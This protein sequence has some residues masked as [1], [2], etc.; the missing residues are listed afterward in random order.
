M[1]RA[2]GESGKLGDRYEA[3]WTVDSLLDVLRGEAE[4]LV[5]E[6][7]DP[8]E[9]LGIEFKKAIPV[10]V[11]FHSAKRQTTRQVW[12]V[13]VL[14]RPDKGRSV[15]GDLFEKLDLDPKNHVVFVSGTTARDLEEICAW[16][17]DSKD[18]VA[19]NSRIEACPRALRRDFEDRILQPQFG[20]DLHKG[21]EALRRIRVVGWT[22]REMIRRV[23]QR[24]RDTLYHT[25]GT[26]LDT[27]ACRV[28]LAEI[29]HSTFGQQIT[30]KDIADFLAK[31]RI[32]ERDW[33]REQGPRALVEKRNAAYIGNVE[34]E[35]IAGG[36][37]DREE[38]TKATDALIQ[39]DKKRAVVIGTAGMGKSCTAAQ[40]LVQL[41][42]N[43]I[44]AV[45]IRLDIQTEVLTSRRLGEELGLP[46]SPAVVLAGIA[47]GG[48]C[49]LVID[50]LDAISFASGRNQRLWQVFEEMLEEAQDYPQMR[51]LLACRAF[52]AEHDPRIRRFLA[53][54]DSTIR[55]D[56]G[57]LSNEAV[58]EIIRR[59]A[60]VDPAELGSAHIDLLRTPLHL[61]LYLQGDP[62]SQPRFSGVQDLFGRYW[63]YKR[64]LVSLQLGRESRWHDIIS[65]LVN[66]LSSDQTLSAPRT[67]LDPFDETEIAI[68]ASLNVIVLDGGSVRFFHEAFFDYCFARLFA[69][70]DQTVLEFLTE[71]GKEQ[72]LF[73]R[74]QV[75][76]ILEYER[77]RNPERYVRNLRDLLTSEKIRYHLKQLTIDWLAAISDPR[78]DEWRL[79]EALGISSALGKSAMYIPWNRPAWVLLL[80]R[81]GVWERWLESPN[82]EFVR[83]AVQ[84]LGLPAAMEMCSKEIAQLFRPYVYSEKNW[85]EEFGHLFSFG[86]PHH[87]LEMFELFCEATRRKLVAAPTDGDWYQYEKLAREK[88]EY[89]V[90]WLSVLL[91]LEPEG[92]DD[93][94][95]DEQKGIRS[96]FILEIAGLAPEAFARE[97]LPRIVKRL[98][99]Q[100]RTDVMSFERRMLFRRAALGGT[101]TLAALAHGLEIAM[102]TLSRESP[103]IL[104]SIVMAV[105]G[106]CHDYWSTLLLSA[107]GENGRHYA[108][109]I[110]AYL[111]D[112]PERLGLKMF[113]WERASGLEA[114]RSA[115]PYCSEEL[116]AK[117]ESQIMDYTASSEKSDPK[118]IGYRRMLLLEA[119]PSDCISH[120]ARMHFEELKRKFPWEKFDRSREGVRG[121]FVRSPVPEKAVPLMNDDQWLE[122]MRTYASERH[123]D[124]S[125]FLKGGKH[126]LSSVLRKHAQIEKARFARLALRLEDTIASE[127]F[128][129]IL[130]GISTTSQPTPGEP[131]LPPS[132]EAPLEA[133]AILE[134]VFRVH[135]I[136]CSECAK[137]I[138]RAIRSISE[139]KPPSKAIEILCNYAMNDPDPAEEQWRERSGGAPMWGGDPH[140]QGMNCVR[141]VAAEA[142]ASLLFADEKY[143]KDI[144]PA[145]HSVIA[146]RSIAVRSCAIVCLLAM[147][148][149]DRDRA[150]QLFLVLC[151]DASP[152]LG[153]HY[154]EEFIHNAT[155]RHYGPLRPVLLR[156]LKSEY[157]DS[158]LIA[159]R[160]IVL[161]AF[162]DPLAMQ[163]LAQVLSGD[164]L[165]RK[166][167][168]EIYAHNLGRDASRDICA[169]HL[170][171]LFH[172][173]DQ[174]VRSAASDCFRLIPRDL[175]AQE[176]ELVFR[177]IESPACLE[178]SHNLIHALEESA[179]PLPEVIC[180]IPERFIAEQR[181][182]RQD[183]N[184]KSRRWTYHLPALVARLY[185]QT[186]DQQTKSRCLDILDGMLELG[187]SN[188]ETELGQVER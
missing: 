127:Y 101:D 47:N 8:T 122:A 29:I 105:G 134:V 142:L 78:E 171:Q 93:N 141:G 46:E 30:R 14:M 106:M 40:T 185:E 107:W 102:G 27:G 113:M 7:F 94:T 52:D 15:L 186:R 112:D 64:R 89:G 177:F 24:I 149:F 2:G 44:P 81:L 22:E 152:V 19:F 103:Q 59:H 126:E 180:R 16:A 6:P 168:A 96:N 20:G 110:V 158:R 10:G 58:R 163:D 121:G 115:T 26:R 12:S 99:G 86:E 4:W 33:T 179:E 188:I 132:A 37:L 77:E 36:R 133:K 74:A 3:I 104:D 55:I 119:L 117:I 21:W 183:E 174:K 155:Y 72:H 109:T 61:N 48:R 60:G 120:G 166:A 62:T 144:A 69:E 128:S 68:I 150:V 45:A 98:G 162:H 100:N 137:D 116:Y 118:M 51:I 156:M 71:N 38:A 157:E 9:S 161:A 88:P 123:R 34:A 56:L 49:V 85:R 97:V 135:A 147:L 140:F 153:T 167:A 65:S 63:T 18:A 170:D 41:R 160:Q 32:A 136:A 1:P 181:A 95:D 84:M 17:A 182:V 91:D 5:V 83:M 57:K 42:E 178:N 39:G 125:D 31:H 25:E 35:L 43:G 173:P 70:R 75:R 54:K 90:I 87:T 139:E 11:E 114:V 66:K 143:L 28:L 154:S 184:I 151:D 131:K 164:E 175:L 82:Q 187:F 73:R 129:A 130:S 53:D 92:S 111:L 13:A 108:D 169:R 172:D 23:E 146:D 165:C 50:Q 148:N 80:M 138:C 159:G 145:V 176:Q 124:S 67:L 79:L 76:Q